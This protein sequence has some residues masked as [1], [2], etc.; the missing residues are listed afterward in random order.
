MNKNY[1]KAYDKRYKQ[2][3]VKDMLWSSKKP[4]KEVYEQVLNYK[5]GKEDSILDLGCGEGRDALF[6]LDR[7]YNVLAVDYS[8]T[9][10]EKCNMLSNNKYQE[11]FKQF[12]LIEDKINKKFKF[13]YSI[14]VLHMFVLDIHRSKYFDFINEHLE[15]DGICLISMLGDGVFEYHS[16][17]ED[18][19]YDVPR[20]ILNCNIK[21]NVATTSCRVVNW[22]TLDTEIEKSNLRIISKWISKNIPEFNSSM[23]VVLS[24]K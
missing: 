1:Y 3:Y 11:S 14:A 10:I 21:I 15:E 18:A 13:I 24:K 6:L 7:G 5:I 2:V 20:T 9:V 4:T 8:K 16:N 12:D 17:I 23:C 19:F 22:E